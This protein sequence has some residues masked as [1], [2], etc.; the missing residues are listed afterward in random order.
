MGVDFCDQLPADPGLSTTAYGLMSG[1]RLL[2]SLPDLGVMAVAT[3]IKM[4]FYIF[5]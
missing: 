3:I 5:A 1:E 4:P 2:R